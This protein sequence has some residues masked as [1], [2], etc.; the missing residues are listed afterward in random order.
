MT[1]TDAAASIV[2]DYLTLGLGLGRHRDG[3]VD[4]Y[5]GPTDLADRVADA[6]P[7][8]AAT[9]ASRARAL[10]RRLDEGEG[11][12]DPQR[13]TW[14]A[15]QVAGLATL[16]DVLDGVDVPYLDEVERCY[17]IVP[18]IPTDDEIRAA[19][20]RLDEVVP[21]AG[22]LADRVA[23]LRR[24]HEIPTPKLRPV[25]DNLLEDFRHRTRQRFG[26]PDG[27]SVSIELVENEPWSGF[28][29]YL[30]DLRS[31]VAIN[32]DLPVSSSGIAH[33][34]AHEAYPGHHTEHCH[35]EVGL[36]RRAGQLEESIFLIGTPSC[37]MAE[38]LADL[39][40]EALLGRD[41]AAVVEEPIRD[42]GVVYDLAAVR[43]LASF[44]EMSAR[45]RGRLAVELH[46]D[47]RSIDDLT[48][49]AARW[50]MVGR[51]R[52]AKSLQFISDPTWSAY[53]FCYAEGHRRCREFV[54][55]D[56]QRFERLL[57]EQLTPA[58]LVNR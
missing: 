55:G 38:G 52:A 50:L 53:V 45:V 23:A 49:D 27:E 14:L 47:G 15:A 43:A 12:L 35:K 11:D 29:Y 44:G 4:A 33:L 1:S 28:N 21:G 30:G 16:A 18:D 46:R 13:R 56:P 31:R 58:D 20:A 22:P 9:L 34:V 37:V 51:D 3:I 25:I 32:T 54:A 2:E 40:L 19:H 57:N 8:A 7:V 36:V 48:V 5:Y 39:G 42:A 26:L 24:R 10:A 17:G 6:P 41:A